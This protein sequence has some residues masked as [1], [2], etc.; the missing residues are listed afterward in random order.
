MSTRPFGPHVELGFIDIVTSLHNNLGEIL[1]V[2]VWIFET[3]MFETEAR[4]DV[5]MVV[6]SKQAKMIILTVA[7]FEEDRSLDA[8]LPSPCVDVVTFNWASGHRSSA[9]IVAP[10][11]APS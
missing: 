9:S 10:Q 1:A 8:R 3:G 4:H 2:A 5:R 11:I 6:I 7:Y